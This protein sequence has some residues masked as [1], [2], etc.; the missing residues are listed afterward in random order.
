MATQARDWM[1]LTLRGREGQVG[2]IAGAR[3]LREGDANALGRLMWHSYRG[4]VDDGGETLEH[5]EAEAL[6]ALAG[7]YG[8]VDHQA[9]CVIERNATLQPELA[10]ATIVV[11]DATRWFTGEAFVAFSMTAPAWKRRGLARAGLARAISVLAQRGE[12][13][14]HL[15]VTRANGP[16]VALYESI[17][18][19]RT[20]LGPVENA[21]ERKDA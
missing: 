3:G 11:R 6:K 12:S 17:G 21:S 15:V 16:A 13:R 20:Q 8:A 4:T 14:L 5:A 2:P 19:V 7:G 10:A 9:T 1:T 18:F